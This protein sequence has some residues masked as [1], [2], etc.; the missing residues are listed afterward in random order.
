M[1][2]TVTGLLGSGLTLAS[3]GQAN[4]VMSPGATSFTFVA[5]QVSGSGYAVTV[6][7]QP[8]SPAQACS[9]AG[10]TGTVAAA[11][12]TSIAITCSSA[13]WKVAAGT[14][15]TLAL[16]RDGTLWVWGS[17]SNGQLGIGSADAGVHSAPVQVASGTKFSAIAAGATH[18]LAIVESG[19][20]PA[21][22]L[23]AWGNNANGRTGLATTTGNTTSPTRVGSLAA[24]V[25]IAVAAGGSHGL[26]IRATAPATSGTLWAWGDNSQSQLGDNTTTQRTSP[27]QVPGAG[28]IAGYTN[29]I[30]VTAGATHS[31]GLRSGG[32]MWGWGDNANRQTG[33]G[34]GSNDQTT[35]V[36]IGSAQTWATVDAGDTHTLAVTTGGA[37][38]AWGNNANGRLGIN[39]TTTQN[40][41]A[42]VSALSGVATVSAGG[43]HS[44]AV[45]TGGA[46]YA[47]GAN[48]N[49]QFGNGA[50]SAGNQLVPLATGLTGLTGTYALSAGGSHTLLAKPDE[51]G[52]SWGLNTSGQL[53]LGTTTQQ[54]S[55]QKI[56]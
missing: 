42:L 10:G 8:G 54:T 38:Y 2:G 15:H 49:G 17:N 43:S 19:A 52:W 56:P 18:S 36:Q 37:L 47:W 28:G 27:V 3:T 6:S 26:A 4:L 25:Y 13:W 5:G 41:P 14:S 1:G 55:P 11:N 31:I 48:P 32:T 29:W 16:R 33:N 24:E 45:T 23:L 21:G 46:A 30:A 53:G 22:A 20:W 35:P 34:N 7:Q 9:V 44:M 51:T 50:T 40:A 12:V 39:N